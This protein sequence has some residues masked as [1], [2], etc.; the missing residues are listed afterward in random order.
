MVRELQ[1][2]RHYG[3]AVAGRGKDG[4][5]ERAETARVL[6]AKIEF[7]SNDDLVAGA[8]LRLPSGDVR[9]AWADQRRTNA[10]RN[11]D[12]KM[13]RLRRRGEATTSTVDHCRALD[14]VIGAEASELG[15]GAN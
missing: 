6:C 11:I 1:V 12:E 3:G 5:G 14:I 10:E 4:T 13:D 15:N 2:P 9:F 8:E 7:E